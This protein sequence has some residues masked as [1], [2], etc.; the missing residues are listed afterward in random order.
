[1]KEKLSKE[2]ILTL[3]KQD[4]V[5][6]LGC[7]EPVCVALCTADA[8]AAIEGEIEKIEVKVNPNIYKNGMS[9]GIPNFDK[10][11]LDFAAALG[12]LLENPEKKLELLGD[13]SEEIANKA[14]KLIDE[15]RVSVSIAMEEKSLY[16]ESCVETN[17][18]KSV[19]VIR[20]AHTNIV[21]KTINSTKV[22]EKEI[23]QA[24]AEN[25]LITRLMNMKI[26]EIRE[27]VDEASVNELGFMI[28]GAL[29]NEEQAQYGIENK[30]GVGIAQTY[31]KQMGQEL[32]ADDLL[33][34]ILLK[35]ASA[36]E[37][38]L[39]GCP[40]ASMSSSGAG[41]KGVVV[42]LP[43]YETAVAIKA[44]KE[45]T[46]KALA[47][48]HLVN[49]YINGYL[50]KLAAVCTCVTASATAASAAI[51]YLLGGNDEQ[52]GFAIRNMTGTVTGMICDGGKVGCALKVSMASTAALTS[53]MLAIHE[54]VIRVTD[55]ICA[56]TPEQCILNMARIGNPGMIQADKE[57]LKIML[58]KQER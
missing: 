13:I 32:L 57:I 49:R 16:V 41:T 55:G 8:S 2:G 29:L 43:I 26:S 14:K 23:T 11:G 50:G 37:V 31:K 17:K 56:K 1:M 25:A 44:S 47:F 33:N 10:V 36:A 6:A 58:E 20:D 28:E 54:S 9:A 12:A 15:E 39:D 30:V 42:I 21:S 48:G 19:T 34:R 22:Y 40:L 46:V 24:G 53:A 7:T 27:V 52:I 38:R 18:G 51:T 35:T 3:L 5:P 45:K 4:V